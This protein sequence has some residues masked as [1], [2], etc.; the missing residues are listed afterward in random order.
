MSHQTVSINKADTA[1]VV[2]V[3]TSVRPQAIQIAIVCTVNICSNEAC[4]ARMERYFTFHLNFVA[5]TI[6][7]GGLTRCN[8]T[9]QAPLGALARRKGLTIN[10]AKSEVVRFNS[11][12][13]NVTALCVGSAPL[14]NKDSFKY[15]GMVSIRR[16]MLPNPLNICLVLSWLDHRIRQFAREHHLNDRPHALL[17]LA[18]CY[19]IPA[20][21]YASQIWGT[22][23]MK[24]GSE[25]D[26][27]LQTAHLCFLKGVLDVKRSVPNWAVLRECGQEPLQFYWFR[28]AAKFFSSLLSGNS[29]LLTK[30][31]H[32]DIALGATYRK[33]WTAELIAVCVGLQAAN[34]YAFCIKAATPLPL[35]DFVMDLRERL[36]AVWRELDGADPRTHAQKLATYHVW[37]ALTL[38]PSNVWGPPHLLPRYLELEVSRHVLRNIARLRQPIPLG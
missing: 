22:R 3:C 19:A 25:F 8:L 9:I 37:M 35:Q 6:A 38:K 29:G 24:Q 2:H 33:C 18:K 32:A 10:T 5:V 7:F 16:I 1:P 27:P 34:T 26:S 11:H 36:R 28:A 23:F 31:V 14:A 4:A 15:L 21:M 30:I 17:W 12:G 20:S 13:C